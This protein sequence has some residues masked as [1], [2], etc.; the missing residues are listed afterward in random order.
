MTMG[1][2]TERPRWVRT[3]KVLSLLLAAVLCVA[4]LTQ[5]FA[6]TELSPLPNELSFEKVVTEQLD[7]VANFTGAWS[8]ERGIV[9]GKSISGPYQQKLGLGTFYVP[10]IATLKITNSTAEAF[11]LEFDWSTED[12]NIDDP[13]QRGSVS[14]DNNTSRKNHFN[15]ALAGGDSI[16]IKVTSPKNTYGTGTRNGITTI[17][18][19]NFKITSAEN[20]SVTLMSSADGSYTVASGSSAKTVEA[21]AAAQTYSFDSTKGITVE[22]APNAGKQFYMWWDPTTKVPYSTEAKVCLFPSNNQTVQPVFVDKDAYAQNFLVRHDNKDQYFVYWEDVMQMAAANQDYEKN[23]VLLKD[24]ALPAAVSGHTGTYVTADGSETT[25][26]LPDGVTLVVPYDAKNDT[27]PT[28]TE[29]CTT[30][31]GQSKVFRKLTVPSG[32]QLKVPSA[33]TLIVNAVQG[34][35]NGAASMGRIVSDYGELEVNGKLDVTGTL[36]ARG[37]VTGSGQVTANSSSKIYQLMQIQDWRGGSVTFG[38][39]NYLMAI[40]MYSFENIMADMTYRGGSQLLVQACIV[41]GNACVAVDVPVMTDGTGV[42]SIFV[43]DPQGQIET[44]YNKENDQL[45]VSMTK[46]KVTM[47]CLTLDMSQGK[48]GLM[49][50]SQK[51]PLAV[52]DSMQ[53]VVK[54]G[55]T[56]QT[57]YKLKFLPGSSV[58]VEKDATMIVSKDSELYFYSRDSYDTR[59]AN[60]RERTRLNY[61]LIDQAGETVKPTED[62]K[63]DVYGTLEVYGTLMQ[64]D[65]GKGGLEPHTGAQIVMHKDPVTEGT[66]NECIELGKTGN[67]QIGDNFYYTVVD[68]WCAIKGRMAESADDGTNGAFT[69]F[70]EMG[71]Y[72]PVSIGGKLYWYQYRVDYTYKL[73]AGVSGVTTPSE[74]ITYISKST[75]NHAVAKGTDGQ[76]FVA[77]AG[78]ADD[79]NVAVT[80]GEASV[81]KNLTDGAEDV[82]LANVTADTAVTLTVKPYQHRVRWE[83]FTQD[84]SKTADVTFD[85]Y[86]TG[87][88][89]SYILEEGATDPTVTI[90]PA[91]GATGTYTAAD[92]TVKIA[93]ISQNIVVTVYPHY[94]AYK[95]LVEVVIPDASLTANL[96]FATLGT[97]NSDYEAFAEALKN[98]KKEDRFGINFTEGLPTATIDAD[99]IYSQVQYAKPDEKSDGSKIASTSFSVTQDIA[100]L[101]ELV[102]TPGIA[103]FDKGSTDGC[104]IID[105]VNITGGTCNYE[106]T[107]SGEKLSIKNI[108]TPVTARITLKHVL[109]KAEFSFNPLP[110]CSSV[111]STVVYD[112]P[113]ADGIYFTPGDK[114]TLPNEAVM[115]GDVNLRSTISKYMFIGCTDPH[116]TF[117]ESELVYD[118]S[119]VTEKDVTEKDVTEGEDT[120]KP[121]TKTFTIPVEVTYYDFIARLQTKDGK[122]LKDIYMQ[123]YVTDQDGGVKVVGGD[124]AY[125]RYDESRLGAKN[126]APLPYDAEAQKT[127]GTS[128]YSYM[129]YT[130]TFDG[131]V[132]L[133]EMGESGKLYTVSQTTIPNGAITQDIDSLAV[134]AANAETGG[135]ATVTVTAKGYYNTKTDKYTAITEN[136]VVTVDPVAYD[137]IVTFVDQS[138]NQLAKQYVAKDGTATYTAA[139]KYVVTKAEITS[140]SDTGTVTNTGTAV[141]VSDLTGNPTI[142]LTTAKYDSCVTWSITKDGKQ[143]TANQFIVSSGST[144]ETVALLGDTVPTVA[145]IEID[146]SNAVLTAGNKL[147]VANGATYTTASSTAETVSQTANTVAV[148]ASASGMVKLELRGYDYTVT[149]VNGEAKEMQYVRNDKNVLSN[150][151]V[152]YKA[153][154]QTVITG[155]TGVTAAVAKGDSQNSSEV[156]DGWTA[157]NLSS[158]TNNMTVTLTTARYDYKLQW[159]IKYPDGTPERTLQPRYV[160]TG[161]EA[162]YEAPDG[163]LIDK[164][165]LADGKSTISEDAGTVTISGVTAASVTATVTLKSAVTHLITYTV[166]GSTTTVDDPTNGAWTYTPADGYEIT[167]AVV[168]GDAGVIVTNLRTSLTIT[169]IT[170]KP[171]NVAITTAQTATEPTA[172][173]GEAVALWGDMSYQYYRCASVYRWN[174]TDANNGQWTPADTFAWRHSAGSRS[175]TVGED[176]YTVPNGSIMLV[177]STAKPVTYTVQLVPNTTKEALLVGMTWTASSGTTALTEENLVVVTVPAH[178]HILVSGEMHTKDSVTVPNDLSGVDIGHITVGTATVSD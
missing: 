49:I 103:T 102:V 137:H 163:Y 18:L 82:A 37:F 8:Q 83:V 7:G 148:P 62:A 166:N 38:L 43:L 177:N 112:T 168:T 57:D 15:K 84:D 104:Y 81:N 52:N 153:L 79:A 80:A 70:A 64:S 140:D 51:Y 86:V 85:H 117:N 47:Q 119:D 78:T 135:N 125:Y 58:T 74:E 147:V 142:K 161:T 5:A 66:V 20:T 126:T 87:T 40:N 106:V 129:S 162:S 174:G 146:G 160:L 27:S 60:N 175:Y 111:N 139:E 45:T 96:D 9:T 50:D 159:T 34:A 100:D 73:D 118:T 172:P 105:K 95:V 151:N 75:A 114:I 152:Y 173:E 127:K 128:K 17:T 98:V 141:T 155:Y 122:V 136:C 88:E 149:F 21:D 115:H 24:Y 130:Y 150:Y 26:S 10:H 28:K 44:S 123:D 56:L 33:A 30:E 72:K 109:Y 71:T 19:S 77:V 133:N 14:V 65:D 89:D 23:V 107:G 157:I 110:Y 178:S 132:S 55:A 68:N 3:A 35:Q 69:P 46:G 36:Y 61:D 91:G 16:I 99:Y 170:D 120:A 156:A 97:I 116:A 124:I 32:V 131:A 134:S 176:R 54:N 6:A 171:I 164:V 59:Y 22:A 90:E 31:P 4:G 93:A 67:Q 2:K 143:Y 92:R 63:L 42:K 154:T 121:F 29:N 94:N 165:V 76:R 158:I 1:H 48:E 53:I 113:E 138:G 144:Y 41:A 145:N 167:G 169:G 12:S 39:Y 25:Y 13:N 101:V 11:T 108:T